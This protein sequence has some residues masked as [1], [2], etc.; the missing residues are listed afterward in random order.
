MASSITGTSVTYAGGGGGCCNVDEGGHHGTGGSGGGAPGVTH[1]A[2]SSNGTALTGGG[3]GG[4]YPGGGGTYRTGWAGGSGVVILR[5]PND[6]TATLA[7]GATSTSGEQSHGSDK[8]I[9][10]ET[11]GT[12]SFA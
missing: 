11:S 8:Y 2:G 12:V 6:R 10:I 3:G 4:R 5:Y 1:N 7:D 9:V